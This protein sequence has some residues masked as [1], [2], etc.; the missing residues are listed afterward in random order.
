M[1]ETEK[2]RPKDAHIGLQFWVQLGQVEVAGFRECQG[3]QVETELFE[4][5]EG[6]LNTYT[7]KFP[8]RSKYKN[9]V[10]KRGL[11]E[12]RDL[13]SWYMKSINGQIQR[14]DISIVVYDSRGNEVEKWDLQRAFPCKWTGPDLNASQGAVAI[15]TLEIAH[16]GVIQTQ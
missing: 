11:D 9:V 2:P 15:E 12:T 1:S 5:S 4:Y 6:G 8:V 16:E 10:L 13:Y 3:L 7:H 14:Q